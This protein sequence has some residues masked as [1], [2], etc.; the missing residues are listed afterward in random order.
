M[1]KKLLFGLLILISFQASGQFFQQISNRYDWL[2]GKFRYNLGLPADT[3]SVT[4]ALQAT[5]WVALKND[6]LWIWSTTNLAWSQMV[7]GGGGS[8]TNEN[9]QDAV[10]GIFG[11]GLFYNDA[12][13]LI[14]IDTTLIASRLYAKKMYDSTKAWV[15]SQSYLTSYTETDPNSILTAQTP[16]YKS[17]QV[18]HADTTVLGTR[19]YSKKIGDSTFARIVALGYITAIDSTVYATRAYARKVADS[20]SGGGTQTLDQVLVAGSTSDESIDLHDAI[21]ENAY[22]SADQ[23]YSGGLIQGGWIELIEAGSFGSVGSGKGAI[24]SHTDGT[25]HY[26]NDAGLDISLGAGSGSGSLTMGTLNSATKSAKGAVIAGDSLVLQTADVSNPGLVSTTSQTFE[27]IKAFDDYSFHKAGAL[28][29]DLSF[30]EDPFTGLHLYASGDV[31]KYQNPAGDTFTLATREY[32]TGRYDS[33]YYKMTQYDDTTALF[34]ARNRVDTFAISLANGDKGDITVAGGWN[35][36]TINFGA[37]TNEKLATGIDA[38]KIADGTVNNT[39]FQYINSLSSNAQTQIDSK[40]PNI[41]FKEEGTNVGSPGA[42]SNVNFVGDGVTATQSG[43]TLTVTIPG[44]GGSGS[45]SFKE[46]KFKTGI[47]DNAPVAG[48][49]VLTHT[50]LVS[51]QV[52]VFR[53]GELQYDSS[54]TDGYEHD[55]TTGNITFHPPLYSGERVHVE[56]LDAGTRTSY[57]LEASGGGDPGD[58]ETANRV[59]YLKHDVGITLSGSDV[60]QWADATANGVVFAANTGTA[61]RPGGPS[62]G[63]E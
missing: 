42:H 1:M 11:Y 30:V 16:L 27:G 45:A 48:D 10:G 8:Y 21:N 44:G 33:A 47:T 26:K 38:I 3:F 14:G 53:E 13:P 62:G 50:Q 29:E 41:Q 37:V 51:S 19:G 23:L 24:Y 34:H 61:A 40:H 46:L 63:R 35:D 58:H 59:F 17:G 28:F 56:I 43:S 22:V 12:T 9:A 55:A 32:V 20:L 2:G 5:P 25:L 36:W 54:S 39:E 52:R 15:Q 4:G 60:D 6:T 49:S 57:A 18:V 7:G 31:F